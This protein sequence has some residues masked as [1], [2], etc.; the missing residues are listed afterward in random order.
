M[1]AWIDPD[2][3]IVSRYLRQLRLGS[4]AH[5]VYTQVLHDFQA[6]AERRRVVDRKTLEAWLRE[7]GAYRQSSTLLHR[8]RIIDRFLDHLVELELI[9][10]NPI[11]VLRSELNVKQC[12]PIWQA[13]A[14]RKP[15]RALAALRRPKPFGSVLG[16]IMREHVERMRTRGYR[17]TTQAAWF[18]RFDR[19]LQAHPE[20]ANEPVATMLEHWSAAKSTRNHAAECEKLK[21]ALIKALRHR[22]PSVPPRRLDARAQ[23]E[24]ARHFRK[25]HIYSPADVQRLLEI[26]RSYPSP[27]AP[28]R[29][30]SVHLMLL[31]AYCAGLRRS[32]LARLDLGDVDLR[33]GAITIRE[34][35]FFKTRILPLPDT[36]MA[37]LRTYIDARRR[38]GAPQDPQSGLFWQSQGNGRYGSAAIAWLLVDIL[39]R[40]GLKPGI[41]TGRTGPRLH[42]LRHSMVVNRMLQWYRSGINPQ[43]RLPFLATYLGHRDINSTLVYITVTQDLMQE[44]SER[45]RVV[46]A[47][48]L[49]SVEEVRP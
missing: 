37:E 47:R 40:A 5:S 9:G 38:A 8:A 23:K 33:S 34:T 46:G 30:M 3:K 31:L 41:G 42:D 28:L 35:K 15:D 7:W 2:R 12:R 39:R 48:C 10:S 16:D 4:N 43:D 14:S 21:H 36:V 45:F 1:T 17:Y 25:P 44:A 24:A 20:L 26:A 49:A 19:F 11:A 32:E 13:L 18:L 27:R 6:V 29:P 22:D